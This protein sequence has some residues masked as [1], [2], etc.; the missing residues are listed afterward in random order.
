MDFY[1]ERLNNYRD[2]AHQ[3]AKA[4]GWWD[5]VSR[6]DRLIAAAGKIA[7]EATELM[8][9][10]YINRRST[11]EE[12]YSEEEKYHPKPFS[13]EKAFKETIKDSAEDELADLLLRVLDLAGA[14]GVDLNWHVAAKFKY[15]KTRGYKHGKEV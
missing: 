3:N 14:M 1:F 15:N 13:Y 12:F 10:L 4:S 5:D 11:A 2:L 8:D 6:P 9:A 7:Q